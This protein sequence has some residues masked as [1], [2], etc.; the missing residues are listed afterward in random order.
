VNIK[1]FL[2]LR[3]RVVVLNAPIPLFFPM[4][5]I[6]PVFPVLLQLPMRNPFIVPAVFVPPMISVI[7]PPSLVY[8]KIESRYGTIMDPATVMIRRAI[9][10]PPPRTPPPPIPEKHIETDIWN[11]VDAVCIRQ[12]DNL[13]RFLTCNGWR[14]IAPRA[15]PAI[16]IAGITRADVATLEKK[17]R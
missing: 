13:R 12:C 5:I 1:L 17:E 8:L 9:P 6:L 11:N 7:F 16:A 10:L 15:T 14:F 4:S 3:Q 2:L